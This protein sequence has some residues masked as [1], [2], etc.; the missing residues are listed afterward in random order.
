MAI[1]DIQ[2]AKLQ[3]EI[4]GHGSPL[5]LVLPQSTGPVGRQA[6]VRALAQHHTVI[7]Y[8]QRG[9]GGSSPSPDAMSI[10]MH[11]E[12]A[13]A[14]LDA[15]GLDQASLLCHSTGCGIGLSVAAQAPARVRALV[16]TAPWTHADHHLLTMQNL[17]KAAARALDPEQYARF[18]AA[19]LFPPAYRRA[20]EAG[21]DRLATEAIAQPHDAMAIARRLDAILDFDARLL[22]PTIRS[23]L[24]VI[25]AQ[26]DQ[27]M[28][29]WFADE[30]GSAIAQAEVVEFDG[31]GHMLPETR[32]DEF[33]STVLAFLEQHTG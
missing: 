23:E 7:T 22:L 17:R 5:I 11:G 29:G 24:L 27:L 6:M 21:F 2:D 32:T 33:V 28:P 13:I 1:A 14:L 30:I 19:L 8:D 12:D 3:Y 20:H 16:L 10:A 31:G 9:T 4:T 18:N 26:D 25:V 15:L